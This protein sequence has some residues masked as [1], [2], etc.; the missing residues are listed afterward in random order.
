MKCLAAIRLVNWYH[1]VDQTF[2]LDGSAL[3]MGD[4]GSGKSTVLDAVQLALVADLTE[5]R[6]NKAA[7]EHSRR[8]L[9]GY[10]RH[11]LGS[12]DEQTGQQRFGRGSCASYVL[13]EFRDDADPAEHFVAGIV[14]DA[15]EGDT[16]VARGHFVIPRGL[17][18]EV[19]VLDDEGYVRPIRAILAVLRTRPEVKI[20]PDVGSYRDELRHRLGVLPP[21]FHRL[22]VKALDFKPIGQVRQFVFDYL[23]DEHRVDT[24]ALQVNLENY[25]RLEAE[26]RAAVRR[27]T[28]L[29]RL[30]E[31]GARIVSSRRT[32]QSHRYVALAAASERAEGDEARIDLEVERTAQALADAEATGARTERQID[33][34][35]RERLRILG[36]L[37]QQPGYQQL[38]QL[39][40]DLARVEAELTRAREADREARRIFAIQTAALDALLAEPM[41]DLRRR[42]PDLLGDDELIGVS[43]LPDIVTRLRATL[44]QSGALVG[45]DVN[46]WNGRL[47]SAYQQL[48]LVRLRLNDLIERLKREGQ[49]LE[50]E[51]KEIDR[52][53][54]QRYGDPIAALLHLL[55]A[56]LK[57]AR[58]PQP[59]CEL[60]DVP[61]ERWRNAVEGYLNTRRFDVIVAPQ[62]FDRALSLYER[63]KT[64]Y[65]LS[66]RGEVFI[67]GVGLVDIEK[68]EARPRRVERHALALQVQTE[69]PLARAYCDFLLG[70][71]ICCDDEH[72]LR[73]HTRAITDTVMV[74]Q[75]HVARQ[76]AREVYARSY[77]GQHAILRRREA[78]EHRLDEIRGLFLTAVPDLELLIEASHACDR[79]RLEV[80]RLPALIDEAE[81]I[82]GLQKRAST[83]QRQIEGVDRKQIEVIEQARRTVDSDLQE[84]RRRLNELNQRIGT[85]REE[86]NGRRQALAAQ[87]DAAATARRAVDE[88]LAAVPEDRRLELEQHYAELRAA[89]EPAILEKKYEIQRRNIESR[90]ESQIR[91]LVKMKA[92]YSNEYGF[93]GDVTSEEWQDFARERDVWRDSHLPAYEARISKAKAGAIEQLAED[94][95]FRL[96]ENL[97]DVRR[98]LDEL[99]SALKEVSFGSDRYSF[100]REVAREHRQFYDLIMESGHFEKESLFAAAASSTAQRTLEELFDRL[101]AGDAQ[102]VRSELEARADYREYFHYDIRIH[103]ADRTYSSFDKVAGDKSGGETQTPY[104]IAVFASMY[105]MYRRRAL[106]RRPGCGLVLLDEAFAKMDES[107]TRATLRFARELGLQLVIAA[108]QGKSE[109]VAPGVETTLLI[110]KD[111]Q[112]GAPT[113]LDFTKEFAIHDS[114]FAQRQVGGDPALTGSA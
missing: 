38:Q 90:I 80:G 61:N 6:F 53:G 93:A 102:E 104:Y 75:N 73:R 43:R 22:I 113:V 55:R 18:E 29:D 65:A 17:A 57:G 12:E 87:R 7:N 97:L 86:L 40:A 8:S 10:V 16:Q 2:V 39:E 108:A 35:D 91:D 13:V 44:E 56:K 79:A 21:S 101:V 114:G 14:M 33:D 52:A 34:W 49:E 50:G 24:E 77:L 28:A 94:V 96:R 110:V 89:E 36:L 41:R 45:R 3:F 1:F 92:D 63:H 27:L 23:L 67:G 25:K 60:V 76:T 9:Y 42:R 51:Q 4:S 82:P 31:Q 99:N 69:D 59:L 64:G 88:D 54:R 62:D 111:P 5:I 46:T 11:K 19:P 100:E 32:I 98:Q 66:G 70:D 103:H 48:G 107:R 106:D 72:E 74:Y 58:E 68:I 47:A 84:A 112:S 15:T 78:I 26:A 81:E 71:V 20:L 85:L 37:Q 83:L 30:C 109:F 95:I 105:R